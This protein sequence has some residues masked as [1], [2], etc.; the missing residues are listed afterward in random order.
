MELNST[1]S[2]RVDHGFVAKVYLLGSDDLGYILEVDEVSLLAGMQDLN[3]DAYTRVVR[4]QDGDF[5]AL[6]LEVALGLGEVERSVVWRSVPR[7]KSVLHLL[8]VKYMGPTNW[9]RR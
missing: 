2:K 5:D 4:L 3:L 8:G 9:S 6:V 1:Y 7:M